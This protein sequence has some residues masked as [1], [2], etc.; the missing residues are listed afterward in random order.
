MRDFSTTQED[1]LKSAKF[2]VYLRVEV[3]NSTGAFKELTSLQGSGNWVEKVKWD[4]DLDKV[5]PEAT[6][7]VRRDITDG[8]S[9]APLDEASTFNVSD[10]GSTAA[11]LDA[12]RLIR[13]YT[14]T[15]TTARMLRYL[16]V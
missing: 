4:W 2:D 7:Q 15:R 1:I 8:K 3:E 6:F 16:T 9:L 12:G 11:L 13:I 14:A 5:V 10:A